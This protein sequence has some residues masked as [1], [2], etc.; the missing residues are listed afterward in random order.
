[1]EEPYISPVSAPYQRIS[2][3]VLFVSCF[4]KETPELFHD[5]RKIFGEFHLSRYSTEIV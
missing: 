5:I 4:S 2:D 3:V 1:M